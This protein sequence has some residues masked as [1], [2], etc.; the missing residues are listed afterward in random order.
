LIKNHPDSTTIDKGKNLASDI[1]GEIGKFIYDKVIQENFSI[2]TPTTFRVDKEINPEYVKLL[3]TALALG[4]IIYL[5]PIECLSHTGIVGKRFRLA[6]FLT[7]HFKIPNRV[8]SEI[9][10]STILNKKHDDTKQL[11]FKY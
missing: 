3:E 9:R 2:T 8:N 1:L 5:N 10:L 4:A 6:A 11:K 7:P